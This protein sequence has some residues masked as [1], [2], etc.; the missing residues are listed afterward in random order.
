M[1]GPRSI[2]PRSSHRARSVGSSGRTASMAAQPLFAADRSASTRRS[3]VTSS[4]SAPGAMAMRSIVPTY[5]PDRTEGRIA[6]TAPPTISRRRSAT[7]M[8]ACGRKTSWRSMSAAFKA[9]P[10]ARPPIWS[11]LSATNRSISVIRAA[12]TVYSTPPLVPRSDGAVSMRPP[13]TSVGRGHFDAADRESSSLSRSPVMRVAAIGVAI[14]A[15]SPIIRH[16]FG[17]N[18]RAA[19]TSSDPRPSRTVSRSRYS[20]SEPASGAIETGA[21]TG[22]GIGSRIR[23]VGRPTG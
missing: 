18:L 20:S 5:P 3:S 4:A 10:V 17:G 8:L 19:R 14:G 15:P 22:I 2:N 13:R 11:P 16:R 9:V 12:R 7:R 1:C 23:N 21:R 6:R